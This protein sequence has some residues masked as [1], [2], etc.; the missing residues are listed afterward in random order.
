MGADGDYFS[1]RPG[2]PGGADLLFVAN[3]GHLPNVDAMRWFCGEIL[4]RVRGLVPG[5]RI[6]IVG[7][8]SEAMLGGLAGM[9]GVNVA[10]RVDDIRP[11]IAGARLFVNPIRLGSG[12]R[13]KLLEAFAMAR[14]V[15]T[16]AVGAQGLEGFPPGC[17][18]VADG[19]E[20]FAHAVASLL[21]SPDKAAAMGRAARAAFEGGYDWMAL[22]GRYEA[23]LERAAGERAG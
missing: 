9:A 6:D 11:L 16:T 18:T 13:G 1:P 5:A 17:F 7:Y 21:Q 20:E 10:G 2:A 14:P 12:M 22:A 4:P 19:A 15:V 23:V 3:F 8:K